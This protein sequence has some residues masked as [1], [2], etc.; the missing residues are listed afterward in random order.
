MRMMDGQK[1]GLFSLSGNFY[2]R[3]FP[4]DDYYFIFPKKDLIT[5]LL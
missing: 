1:N 2:K 3:Y 4:W 5:I